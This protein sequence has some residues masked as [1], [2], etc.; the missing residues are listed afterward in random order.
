MTFSH[1]A[2]AYQIAHESSRAIWENVAKRECVIKLWLCRNTEIHAEIQ[3]YRNTA[4]F[5]TALG[6]VNN[7]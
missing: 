1:V 6:N 5:A 2:S 3:K 7:V 4:D